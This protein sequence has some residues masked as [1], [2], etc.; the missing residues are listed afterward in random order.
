MPDTSAN[1][2]RLAKNTIALYFRTFI[3][4]I[5]GLY[6]GRVMLQALGVYDYGVN[7][8]VGG[9]IGFS[10]VLTGAMSQAI[11]R[12]ISY[13]LGKSEEEKLKVMFSTTINAQIILSVVVAFILEFVGIWFLNTKASLPVGRHDAALWVLHCSIITLIISIVST[14]FNALIIAHEKMEVYAYTSI[15]EAV[16][17]L[18][19]CF[20]I[21]AY[22]GDRLILLAILNII[23]AAIMRFF[24]GWY[25]GKHFKE[26]K[27][28]IKLFDKGLLREI[29]AFSGWNLLTNGAYVF[30]T[31]GVSLITNVFFGVIF[32]AS[33]AIAITVN[34]A[35]QGFVQNFAMAFA[36]QIMKSYAA[37]DADYAIRL[38]N[39][40]TRFTWL[41]MYLFIVPICMESDMLLKLW[42]GEVPPSASLFLKLTMFE[43]LA[44]CS[45]SSYYKLLQAEGQIKKYCIHSG[46]LAGAIL[47]LVWLAYLLGAP[48]WISY[49]ISS[50]VFFFLN[51]VRLR[52]IKENMFFSIKDALTDCF[53]PCIIVSLTS[54]IVPVIISF[55]WEQSLTRFFSMV[56]ISI[57]WTSYCCA[58]WGLTSEE[59]DFFKD[60]IYKT[61]K[62]GFHK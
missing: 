19:T 24:Y 46:L 1:N 55:L 38:T 36:P 28:S 30:S 9:I 42:L 4:L 59:R 43:S 52:D 39:R 8:V 15:A 34:H 18:A 17:R 29:S 32:N 33:R 27:Y 12:Y 49:I 14:P 51:I 50:F 58:I 6:T 40:S 54:F 53:V 3:T 48:I 31:Q 11:S 25:C 5:V 57:L 35:V 60:K 23:V 7:S 45:G 62:T 16:F 47:P 37:G 61:I 26:T 2:K 10:A 41:L 22:G 21:M 44:I 20:M 56:F 13:A